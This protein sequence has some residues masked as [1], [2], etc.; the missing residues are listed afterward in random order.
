MKGFVESSVEVRCPA[1]H[2]L[3]LRCRP[4]RRDRE[5]AEPFPTLFWL[6]CDAVSAQI[7]RLESAGHIREI[8]AQ[9]AAD[10]E[11]RTRVHAD[12][13]AY[14]D[15]RWALLTEDERASLQAAG[16]DGALRDRG[17]G[18]ITNRDAVKCLHLHYAHHLA[19]GSAIGA[20]IDGLDDIRLCPLY[21]VRTDSAVFAVS[22]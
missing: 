20:I 19:R 10:P 12:H 15:E 21:G 1:G 13:D 7:A 16:R 5:P 22:Q 17:I 18:G 4:V 14:T 6:A 11:L 8:E 9:I 3:V 2:A